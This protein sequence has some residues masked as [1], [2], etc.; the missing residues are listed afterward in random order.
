MVLNLISECL[1]S[2]GLYPKRKKVI[3]AKIAI[4]MIF[5]FQSERNRK[6][7]FRN[8]KNRDAF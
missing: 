6:L 5:L 4:S 8:I 7:I 1:N 3:F 2:S